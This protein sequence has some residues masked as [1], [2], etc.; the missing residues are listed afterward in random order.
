M[1][2]YLIL[3]FTFLLCLQSCLAISCAIERDLYLA[4]IEKAL[5]FSHFDEQFENANYSNHR[6]EVKELLLRIYEEEKAHPDF[7]QCVTAQ[8][9]F[10]YAYQ[11]IAKELYRKLYGQP[12][13]DFEFLRFPTQGLLKNREDFFSHYP[14]LI[15]SNEEI[16]KQFKTTPDKL[17]EALRS[18]EIQEEEEFLRISMGGEEFRNEFDHDNDDEDDIDYDEDDECSSQFQLNDT[19]SEISKELISVNFTMETYLTLDSAMFVFLSGKSVSLSS[20]S[21]SEE[22][23]N[24]KINSILYELFESYS[25]PQEKLEIC[26]EKLIKKAPRTDLGIINQIFLP[27]ENVANFL[28]LSFGGGFLHNIYDSNFE[29][30]YSEFQNNRMESSFRTFRNFQARIIAGSLF[31]DPKVKIIRYTLISEETQRQ[32]EV[33]VREAIDELFASDQNPKIR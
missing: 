30:S 6:E 21:E 22:A 4:N 8:D 18:Y 20:L 32:Y 14:S 28:Y 1:K 33:I 5:H 16:A 2:K 11:V 13:D 31:E 29:E 15:I 19:M 17:K 10:F 27:K 23:Y 3:T 25:L 7:I 24:K 26:I 12:K 9:S